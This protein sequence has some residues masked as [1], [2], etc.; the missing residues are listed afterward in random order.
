MND[1]ILRYMENAEVI[2]DCIV[3]YST[4]IYIVGEFNPINSL[5]TNI[6]SATIP[7]KELEIL[8]NKC[9]KW[10]SEVFAKADNENNILI[11]KDFD[12]ISEEEQS[13]FIDL[14]CENQVSTKNLPDNLKLIINAEKR[15]PLISRISDVIQYFEM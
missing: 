5:T 10:L 8:N 7:K 9:P 11:I 6:I 1:K 14:I 4:P 2:T 13:L 3:T 12:K 15:C